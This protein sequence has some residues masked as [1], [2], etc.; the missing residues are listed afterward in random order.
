MT[1]SIQELQSHFQFQLSL[2]RLINTQS[3]SGVSPATPPVEIAQH[4]QLQDALSR[5]ANAVH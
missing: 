5:I 4:E 3:V 2:L 1:D